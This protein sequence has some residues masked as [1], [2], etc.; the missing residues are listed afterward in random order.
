MVGEGNLP[1]R[2]RTPYQTY[3]DRSRKEFMR[4]RMSPRE[5]SLTRQILMPGPARS[6]DFG[7]VS[8]REALPPLGMT[9]I[10]ELGGFESTRGL[11]RNALL[12]LGAKRPIG[13]EV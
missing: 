12:F 3:S 2:R 6:F 10:C 1:R 11:L 7:S 8:F 5:N 4:R 13:A 9:S